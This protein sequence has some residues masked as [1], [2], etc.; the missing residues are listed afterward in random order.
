[1]ERNKRSPS[2]KLR[3]RALGFVEQTDLLV[4]A[5][6]ALL[7]KALVLEQADVLTQCPKLVGQCVDE[8]FLLVEQLGHLVK[9]VLLSKRKIAERF[10]VVGK[11]DG[12][13]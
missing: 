1:M 8:R 6:L 7:T 13:D 10:G 3:S 4:R 5:L 12:I 9:L 11:I 2:A